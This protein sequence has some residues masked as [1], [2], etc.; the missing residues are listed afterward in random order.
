LLPGGSVNV[1]ARATGIPLRLGKASQALQHAKPR[2]IPVGMAGGRPFL[3]MAGIGLD[4]EV[5]RRL[6]PGFKRVAGVFAFWIRGFSLL[7]TYP[8]SP[9]IVRIGGREY[10]ATSAI[11]GKLQYYGGRYV[12]TPD[13]ELDEPQLD[14]V[15]FQGR[16]GWDYLRYLAGVLV[17]VHL[18]FKDVQHVKTDRLEIEAQSWISYQLDGE[19]AGRSPVEISIRSEALRILIPDIGSK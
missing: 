10:T 2:D 8:F 14:V 18:R 5:V 7:A 16:R 19:F 6:D 13:A 11:A 12:I 4:A 9:F 17:G 1:F 15:I 3:L